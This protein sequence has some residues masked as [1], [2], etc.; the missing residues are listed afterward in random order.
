MPGES[1]QDLFARVASFYG[2][3]QAHA[4]RLYDYISKLWLI[5]GHPVLSNGGTKRG[6]PISCFL[7]EANDSLDGIVGC[8]TRMSGWPARAA[9]SAATGAICAPSARKSARRQDLGCDPVHTGHGLAHLGD[10]PGLAAPRLG[11]GLSAGSP[12]PEIEEFVEIRRPTGGDPN[13][14]GTQPASRHPGVGRFHARGRK[15]TTSGACARRRQRH[16]PQDLGPVALDPL[17]SPP[18]SKP[19]NRIW[20]FPTT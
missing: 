11:R 15:R 14:K 10:Q 17:S 20:C 19:A 6:L 3:D 12:I 5:A 1:Y 4:Q 8:G 2:D 7:N 18:A 13:R 9:A 16:R